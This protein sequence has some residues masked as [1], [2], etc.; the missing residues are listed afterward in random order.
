MTLGTRITTA[1]AWCALMIGGHPYVAQAGPAVFQTRD[2]FLSAIGDTGTTV[3]FDHLVPDVVERQRLVAVGSGTFRIQY[4]NQLTAPISFNASAERI[5]TALASLAGI[6]RGHIAVTKVAPTTWDLEFVGKLSGKDLPLIGTDLRG[7][8]PGSIALPAGIRDGAPGDRVNGDVGGGVNLSLVGGGTL[9]VTDRAP[10]SAATRLLTPTN[11]HG[12]RRGDSLNLRFTEP[13]RSVGLL[14]RAEGAVAPGGLRLETYT[15]EQPLVITGYSTGVPESG[16]EAVFGFQQIQSITKHP[17]IDA[18]NGEIDFG[19]GDNRTAAFWSETLTAELLEA[20]LEALPAGGPGNFDVTGPPGGVWTIRFTGDFAGLNMPFIDTSTVSGSPGPFLVFVTAGNNAPGTETRYFIGIQRDEFFTEA[21]LLFDQ[22]AVD[23][24]FFVEQIIH[25]GIPG[26]FDGDGDV[27]AFDLGIWQTGFDTTSGAT[28]S[29][30]DAD[31][32]GDVD[33]FDL[34]L[35][36]TNFGTGVGATV[37]EPATAFLLFSAIAL[38][39]RPRR[40]RRRW[41]PTQRRASDVVSP[42]RPTDHPR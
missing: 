7:A 25:A 38:G 39:G 10:G 27:D 12:F 29:D 36:Q 40:P 1:G 11:T 28:V 13:V 16:S 32:D 9:A 17:R 33:A 2:T 22:D 23:G 21:R 24:R 19:I 41:R 5:E 6:G 18:G 31:G 20:A 3:G 42:I 30:G 15:D 26:D 4:K 37:P 14:L 8:S 35:W 34:G